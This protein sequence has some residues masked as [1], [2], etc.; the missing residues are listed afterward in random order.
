LEAST[1]L[2]DAASTYSPVSMVSIQ[3]VSVKTTP[4]FV[5]A[6]GN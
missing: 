2:R 3:R 4:L 6:D 5:A 1:V